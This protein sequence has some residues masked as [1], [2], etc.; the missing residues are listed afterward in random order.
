VLLIHFGKLPEVKPIF[1]FKA[2]LEQFKQIPILQAQ[3]LALKALAKRNPLVCNDFNATP[4][5]LRT[6]VLL[7]KLSKHIKAIVAK[8]EQPYKAVDNA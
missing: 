8:M 6:A 1:H 3:D 4:S 2:C 5:E 7:G